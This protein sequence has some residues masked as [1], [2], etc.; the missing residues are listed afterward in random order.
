MESSAA[1]CRFRPSITILSVKNC[2]G[3]LLQV[4]RTGLCKQSLF[5][6]ACMENNPEV[7]SRQALYEWGPVPMQILESWRKSLFQD[8]G[9]LGQRREGEIRSGTSPKIRF[10]FWK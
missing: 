6:T 10:F 5:G 1:H 4:D 2:C 3:P 8:T 9:A 7:I